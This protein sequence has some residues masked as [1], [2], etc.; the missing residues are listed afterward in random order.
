VASIN[1]QLPGLGWTPSQPG[2]FP[3]A[4]KAN[5][6]ELPTGP[7]DGL[8]V[9]FSKA[10][11]PSGKAAPQAPAADPAP[12]TQVA[13]PVQGGV[14]QAAHDGGF[15]LSSTGGLAMLEVSPAGSEVAELRSDPKAN[16]GNW[17]D[18][19]ARP[20]FSAAMLD[21]VA[22]EIQPLI[23]LVS[24]A[25]DPKRWNK[26]TWN[27]F[28]L[29]AGLPPQALTAAAM[30][31]ETQGNVQGDIP[32]G[33]RMCLADPQVDRDTLVGMMRLGAFASQIVEA[34]LPSLLPS[35]RTNYLK[36]VHD[37]GYANQQLARCQDPR[38]VLCPA[39]SPA[40]LEEAR[41]SLLPPEVASRFR[42]STRTQASLS[43]TPMAAF[44]KLNLREFFATEGSDP[45]STKN[46]LAFLAASGKDVKSPSP[47]LEGKSMSDFLQRSP[48]ET[49]SQWLDRLGGKQV[50]NSLARGWDDLRAD[51][52]RLEQLGGSGE[53]VMRALEKKQTPA[54]APALL[55]LNAPSL[56]EEAARGASSQLAGSLDGMMQVFWRATNPHLPFSDPLI[57]QGQ[58]QLLQTHQEQL[59]KD[60]ELWTGVVNLKKTPIL[61]GLTDE[62]YAQRTASLPQK[63]DVEEPK[64]A[65]SVAVSRLERDLGSESPAFHRIKSSLEGQSTDSDTVMRLH[66]LRF[67]P[68]S[69]AV[70][71]A[72]GQSG[73]TL[74]GQKF[75]FEPQEGKLVPEFVSATTVAYRVG[76]GSA[77][78]ASALLR[79]PK[80][81]V[82]SIDSQD[83]LKFTVFD[84][85]RFNDVSARIRDFEMM[86]T[87]VNMTSKQL[88]TTDVGYAVLEFREAQQDAGRSLKNGAQLQKADVAG[89]I[90]QW[91]AG[92]AESDPVTRPF[93]VL[94]E[95]G[96]D[97]YVLGK[98]GLQGSYVDVAVP[99][100]NERERKSFG[101]VTG[102]YGSAANWIVADNQPL[103]RQQIDDL[104]QGSHLPPD[105]QAR[106]DLFVQT[107]QERLDPK[108][109]V[110]TSLP[111]DKREVIFDSFQAD[112]AA[113]GLGLKG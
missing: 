28:Q 89:L 14:Q 46:A 6:T 77:E 62:T 40:L 90:D 33:L 88:L 76:V 27:A 106:R 112:V 71:V 31:I 64:D 99:F 79:L 66:A 18:A 39:G 63:P 53:S 3:P 96:P 94:Y 110:W 101:F 35:E 45:Q 102:G 25:P 80:G 57:S 92:L 67:D 73:F 60:R 85:E 19:R 43:Q 9:D 107:M 22:G 10:E 82:P 38:S 75:S 111:A 72:P 42:D 59:I 20:V 1:P 100:R 21:E 49:R 61:A 26:A 68:Q 91:L 56:F 69:F 16:L 93:G 7:A 32:P 104:W 65:V 108:H 50:I 103:S 2:H 54:L 5:P 41:L 78:G 84:P 47:E 44:P 86:D 12:T 58:S 95:L 8:S 29:T 15:T 97:N 24:Q 23:D 70:E 105:Q 34:E 48:T 4:T 11:A 52:A 109:A 98:D 51:A 74:G 30:A 83:N 37:H 87:R 81:A 113:L 17:L 13:V 55:V 36:L